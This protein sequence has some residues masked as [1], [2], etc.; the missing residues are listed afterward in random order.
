MVNTATLKTE[1]FQKQST[2]QFYILFEL[3]CLVLYLDNFVFEV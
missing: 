1:Y 2:C 3:Q